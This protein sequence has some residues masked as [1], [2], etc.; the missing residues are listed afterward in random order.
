MADN[1]TV[2]LPAATTVDV[3]LDWFTPGGKPPTVQIGGA[4]AAVDYTLGDADPATAPDGTVAAGDTA[5][6]TAHLSSDA[7]QRVRLRSATATTVDVSLHR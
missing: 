6:V 7:Q 1:A 2:D 4:S 5:T 3:T